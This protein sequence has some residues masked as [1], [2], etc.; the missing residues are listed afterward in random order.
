VREW[1][2]DRHPWSDYDEKERADATGFERERRD[3]L[4][5]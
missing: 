2:E 5:Y 1:A 4:L 3:Y